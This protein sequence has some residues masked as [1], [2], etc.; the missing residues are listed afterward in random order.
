[1]GDGLGPDSKNGGTFVRFRT[2]L[3]GSNKL[4]VIKGHKDQFVRELYVS[5]DACVQVQ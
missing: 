4:H 1:M 2:L 5:E 3:L